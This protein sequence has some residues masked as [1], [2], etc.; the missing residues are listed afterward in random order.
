MIVLKKRY[1]TH[2]NQLNDGAHIHNLIKKYKEAGIDITFKPI[3]ILE[4]L[5]MENK[6]SISP[7]ELN[8]MEMALIH[9]LQPE[10]NI[11]GRLKPYVFRN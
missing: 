1:N 5:Q 8:C 4:T 11:E 9:V 10:G 6:R 3:V 7:K 2:K